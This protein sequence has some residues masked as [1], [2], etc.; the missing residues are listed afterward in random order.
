MQNEVRFQISAQS[1]SLNYDPQSKELV[2]Y[3][4]EVISGRQLVAVF[5]PQAARALHDLLLAAAKHVGGP[6]GAEVIEPPSLQ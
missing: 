3:C 4:A 6:L 5:E 1:F 2:L